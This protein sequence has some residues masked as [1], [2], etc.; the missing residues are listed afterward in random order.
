MAYQST[1]GIKVKVGNSYVS[2]VTDIPALG[3]TP[4]KIDV[5]T[6][7][8]PSRKY[9]NGVKD[10]GDLEFSCLY[11]PNPEEG[12]INFKQLRELEIGGEKQ[13]IIVE[14]P[15][16][17]ENEAASFTLEG[18]IAVAMGEAAVNAA[19]TFTLSVALTD[20]IKFSGDKAGA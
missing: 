16:D 5:T 8:D 14:I 7:I 4:E 19:L 17:G 13:T 3:A 12:K 6:L 11:D 15:A 18:T 2:G 20:E 1:I 9:I 10:Y